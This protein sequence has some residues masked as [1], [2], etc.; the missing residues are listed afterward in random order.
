MAVRVTDPR[1]AELPDA[2]IVE[3]QDAEKRPPGVGRYPSSR[4]VR[5]HTPRR[6]AAV[7]SGIVRLLS[8]HRIDTASVA[9]DGDYVVELMKL[10]KRR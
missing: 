7:R 6:G 3:L 1:E 8:Q 5:A 10:F 4:A 2:G 9:T